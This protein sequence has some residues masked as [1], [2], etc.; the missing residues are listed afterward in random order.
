MK[1]SKRYWAAQAILIGAYTLLLIFG[2]L[3]YN[4]NFGASADIIY[5]ET[6]Q[7]ETYS[8]E[9]LS[10][11]SKDSNC[12]EG[13]ENVKATYL[14]SENICYYSDT[15]Y[16]IGKCKDSKNVHSY[17]TLAE[18][19]ESGATGKATINGVDT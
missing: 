6:Q 11:I 5:N 4:I 12:P 17:D 8:I 7:W 18:Y 19:K 10:Y 14:G 15:E 3:L 16:Y 13:E 2:L 1:L 9:S